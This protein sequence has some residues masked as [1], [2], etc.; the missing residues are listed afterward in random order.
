MSRG[1]KHYLGIDFSGNAQSWRQG[2]DRNVW[3]AEATH[4]EALPVLRG[5]LPVQRLEGDRPPFERLLA[6]LRRKEFV[7]AAIDA[8]F[9]IPAACL[10]DGD[11]RRQA[12]LSE[13]AA[14]PLEGGRPFPSGLQ[15]V[16][17]VSARCFWA[18]KKPRRLTERQWPVNVRS[19]LWAGPRGGAPFARRLLS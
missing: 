5:L 16:A 8:P 6:K 15:L 9:S 17:A 18:E 14:L 4:D 11:D 12:L 19:T 1:G 3:I 10:P 7:A 2:P 13:V